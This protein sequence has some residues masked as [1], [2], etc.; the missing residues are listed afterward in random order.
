MRSSHPAKSWL[1]LF[2][3]VGIVLLLLPPAGAI[4]NEPS[5]GTLPLTVT[6]PVQVRVVGCVKRGNETGRYYL[7][8]QN[9]IKW[10][11]IPS[12]QLNLAEYVNHSVAITGKP[13]A[14][15]QPEGVNEATRNPDTNTRSRHELRILTLKTLSPSCTR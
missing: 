13:T 9:G 2:A 12:G 8:D 1:A 11:L 14:L 5:N 10:E 7:S 4:Q 15:S 6:P 3:L